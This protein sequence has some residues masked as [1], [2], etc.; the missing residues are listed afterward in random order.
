MRQRL[1]IV[2][3]RGLRSSMWGRVL[4]HRHTLPVRESRPDARTLVD[5]VV[6]LSAVGPI[7]D[8]VRRNAYRPAI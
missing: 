2:L 6:A 5:E 4:A 1:R 8:E 3:P 7:R